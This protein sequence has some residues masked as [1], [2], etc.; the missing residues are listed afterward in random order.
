MNFPA[1]ELPLQLSDADVR[2]NW[3]GQVAS[4]V[5]EYLLLATVDGRWVEV[6]VY[7]GRSTR[8]PPRL[9]AAQQE[10]N[11]LVLPPPA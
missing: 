2:T 7:F 5:P 4:N 10:L 6:R 3:E 9:E 11:R 8:A 1:R